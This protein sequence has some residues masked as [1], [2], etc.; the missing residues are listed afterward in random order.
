MT[1]DEFKD[2][3][4][5][6]CKTRYPTVFQRTWEDYERIHKKTGGVSPAT[7]LFESGWVQIDS[8]HRITIGTLDERVNGVVVWREWRPRA[9]ERWTPTG[10]VK[11]LN[12]T[13]FDGDYAPLPQPLYDSLCEEL[14]KEMALDLLADV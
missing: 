12:Y 4:L 13:P 6:R 2:L 5:K 11:D 8:E 1:R 14:R 10:Y 7:S 3:V 9:R